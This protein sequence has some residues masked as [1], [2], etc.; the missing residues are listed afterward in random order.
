MKGKHGKEGN[1]MT[2]AVW[3]SNQ[4]TKPQAALDNPFTQWT[5]DRTLGKSER[6]DAAADA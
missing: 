4:L 5:K 1:P 6:N 2:G 3:A